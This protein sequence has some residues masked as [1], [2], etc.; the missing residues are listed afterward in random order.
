MKPKPIRRPGHLRAVWMSYWTRWQ[1]MLMV[2]VVAA[3][4]APL[5]L[6]MWAGDPN[7]VTSA[8]PSA[9]EPAPAG[10]VGSKEQAAALDWSQLRSLKVYNLKE[11]EPLW[12]PGRAPKLESLTILE[13]ITDEQ[14]AKICELYDLKS[15][16]LYSPEMLTAE[17]WRVFQ[18]ETKLT[19]LR[20]IGAHALH[21][22]PSL[23]WP[24]NLQ[25]L[26]AGNT[27]GKTQQR[28]DE[29]QRLPHLTC[30]STFLIPQQGDQLAPEM[31]DTLKRFPS[32]RRLYLVEMGKH[33]PDYITV[34]QAALPSVRV[35]P[36]HYHPERGRRAAMIV[37]VGLLVIVVLSVQMSSQFVTT[38]SVLTPHFARSHL[39]LVIG[40]FVVLVAV[41][42]G[43]LLWAE[44]SVFAALCLCG[45]S[46]LL[47][48]AGTKTMSLLSG[49]H[50]FPGFCNFAIILPSVVFPVMGVLLGLFAF[51]ADIDWFL[52]GEQ[53][54]L[55]SIVLAGS[56]W[57]ACHLIALQTGMRRRLEEAGI[58]NVPMG[59]F[60]NRGWAEWMTQQAAGREDSTTKTPLAYRQ[61]D[62]SMS[63]MIERL[64]SGKRLTLLELWPLGGQSV[65]PML[66]SYVLFIGGALIF[67][68]LPVALLAPEMWDRF[69]PVIVGPMILQMFGGGLIFPLSFAWIRRPM[70]EMELLRPMSRRD[71]RETWFR[72][73]AAEMLPMLLTMFAFL[74]VLWSCGLL[75]N[76][77]A[78]QLLWASIIFFGVLV[79]VFAV[80]ME[81][82]TLRSLW[83]CA[84]VAGG[85]WLVLV[86]MLVA[87]MLLVPM[88]DRMYPDLDLKWESPEFLIPVIGGLY[89]LAAFG[90]TIAWRRWMKWEVSSVA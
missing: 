30:L 25:T 85:T 62:R 42:L 61:F 55:A 72:G 20:L 37:I 29:W 1:L 86:L 64:Q 59:M 54:V 19:F 83:Q 82:F 89:G 6:M 34:Q 76:W 17:G 78:M 79:N 58:A 5:V 69:G 9:P 46:A 14:L 12:T 11:C 56:L 18:G 88:L 45:A 26:I 4:S 67:V 53:P 41:S 39:S 13:A 28:L 73:V 70:Q 84:L 66:K 31:L 49:G 35:R 71:W 48:G 60:D 24:P 36:A 57:G 77:T 15:L 87:F 44:C 8:E 81:A 74:L 27:H 7:T 68:G 2:I 80:G 16:T 10:Y 21:N 23:A 33:A 38:A 52:R 32:L 40:V 63:R 65:M 22:E 3:A 43:L 75:G 90:L 47:L 51:G 50:R